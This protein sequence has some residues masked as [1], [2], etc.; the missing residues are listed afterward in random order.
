MAG[1]GS[2][3][4][5]ASRGETNQRSTHVEASRDPIADAGSTPAASIIKGSDNRQVVR[6]LL[7]SRACAQRREANPARTRR[8]RGRTA[9][10]EP[11]SVAGLPFGPPDY[12]EEP[13]EDQR[14][15]LTAG[16]SRRLDQPRG[17]AIPTTV[18][19]PPKPF[20]LLRSIGTNS[21]CTAYT[22]AESTSNPRMPE[23]AQNSPS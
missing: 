12:F 19:H 8:S 6:A 16:H 3:C 18:P 7:I 10:F 2:G 4:S 1:R 13:T 23:C 22:A 9:R 15:A 11:T 17:Q 5:L 21:T 20:Y 14:V